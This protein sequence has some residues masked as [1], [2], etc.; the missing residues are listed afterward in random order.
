MRVY[1]KIE[2]RMTHFCYIHIVHILKHANLQYH[3]Q[4]SRLGYT[5][6]KGHM[7]QLYYIH[8]VHLLCMH[9]HT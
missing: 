5:K 7:K 2:G 4:L 6:S 9:T 1:T 8:L 3:A